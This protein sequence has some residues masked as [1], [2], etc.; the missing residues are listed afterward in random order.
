MVLVQPKLLAVQAEVPHDVP[1]FTSDSEVNALN[2]SCSQ[3]L[4]ALTN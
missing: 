4:Q 3:L 1:Q 2:I